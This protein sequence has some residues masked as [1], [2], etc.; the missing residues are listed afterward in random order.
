MARAAT[1]PGELASFR[2]SGQW[3]KRKIL[4]DEPT[5][6][7]RATATGAIDQ[8][9]WTLGF[10]H[11]GGTLG[12]CLEDM[13]L[14]VGSDTDLD[15]I[16]I[17]RLRKAP[18]AGT[19]Y[20]GADPSV[21]VTVGDHLTVLDDFEV[22]A[23]HSWGELLD[24]DVALG[25][26]FTDPQPYPIMGDCAIIDVDDTIGFDATDAWVPGG[27]AVTYA[28]TFTGASATTGLTTATPTATYDTAGRY[29]AKL[30]ATSGG[31]SYIGY[32]YIFVLGGAIAPDDSA[33]IEE[34]ACDEE[35][36]WTCQAMLYDRPAICKRRRA[37]I[38]CDDY[39]AGAAESIG[40]WSGRE[41]IVLIGR[42]ME[43]SIVRQPGEDWV[44]FT[45]GNELA[46]FKSLACQPAGLTDEDFPTDKGV[47]LPDWSL[48]SGLTVTKGLHYLALHRSTM[49][50][51]LDL[52]VEDWEWACP[53]LTANSETLAGQ[54]QDFADHAALKVRGDR[55]GRVYV[56]RDTQI[57]PVDDRTADIPVVMTITDADW[58]E[59]L[60]VIRRQTGMVAEAKAEGYVYS[61][62]GKT[63][64][65]TGGRSPGDQPARYGEGESIDEVYFGALSDALEIAGLMAGAQNREIERIM[66]QMGGNVRLIDTAPRQFVNMV[67]DGT[68]YRC[69]PRSVGLR[70]DVGGHMY[71]ELELEPEG[72]EWPAVKIDYPEEGEPPIVNPPEPP[73]PPPPPEEPPEPPEIGDADAVVVI[74][75]DIETTGN[76]DEASPTWESEV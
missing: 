39:Y 30:T 69:I 49:A 33:V 52:R 44:E 45:V 57:Y 28:W 6:L 24:V 32:R 50:R 60:S 47:T 23:K 55:Y 16:G 18:V 38:Y 22:F 56:E 17:L 59:E 61:A 2:S 66:F 15:D 76:L 5:V 51:C 68:T 46:L 20:V 71:T 43:E 70:E 54:L 26:K 11:V 10:V 74:P 9:D 53:Y 1:D 73:T 4:I 21:V 27:A 8:E 37:I 36:A 34:P 29:R 25:D 19:F 64:T 42:I 41:N 72:G 62:A 58:R 3:S 12:L 40:P 67:V 75:D 13:T 48:I 7:Y 63:L 14:L 31:K 35:G 65:R